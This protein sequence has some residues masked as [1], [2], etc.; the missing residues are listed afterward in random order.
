MTGGGWEP[1]AAACVPNGLGAHKENPWAGC[2]RRGRLGAEHGME[3][4]DEWGWTLR[5]L[6]R[7]GMQRGFGEREKVVLE[8]DT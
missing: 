1:L 2:R 3:I 6:V 5:W 4:R 7:G 8:E